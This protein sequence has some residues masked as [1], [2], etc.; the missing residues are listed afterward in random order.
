MIFCFTS[1]IRTVLGPGAALFF[2]EHLGICLTKKLP[3]FPLTLHSIRV[4]TRTLSFHL[5]CLRSAAC[6]PG[7]QWEQI[8]TCLCEADILLWGAAHPPREGFSAS[9]LVIFEARLFFVVGGHPA[10]CGALSSIP[11]LYQADA[12]HL[13]PSCDNQKCPLGARA[14]LH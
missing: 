4:R 3:G 5:R 12:C 9:A 2:S 1:S 8:S 7:P 6:V 11:G 13:P 10:Y 14:G